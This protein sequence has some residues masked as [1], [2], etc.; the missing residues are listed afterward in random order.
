MQYILKW[1]ELMFSVDKNK[2]VIYFQFDSP[3]FS[4]GFCFYTII[5]VETKRVIAFTVATKDMVA[6]SAQMGMYIFMDFSLRM[7]I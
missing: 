7:F 5:Q 2:K 1:P 6:Y 3:G 4:A